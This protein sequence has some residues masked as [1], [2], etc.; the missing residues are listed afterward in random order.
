MARLVVRIV[1]NCR[2]N[3][4]MQPFHIPV[5]VKLYCTTKFLQL[6][7]IFHEIKQKDR[8]IF[9]DFHIRPRKQNENQSIKLKFM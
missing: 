7:P 8:N 6:E 5:Q 2:L 4:K 3:E 9:H 1:A